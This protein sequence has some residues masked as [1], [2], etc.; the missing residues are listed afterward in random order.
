MNVI[1]VEEKKTSLTSE[2]II[3]QSSKLTG[4]NNKCRKDT[5][6][7]SRF[8]HEQRVPVVTFLGLTHG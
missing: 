8:L 2:L 3:S 4:N 7:F 1:A 5:I 6:S